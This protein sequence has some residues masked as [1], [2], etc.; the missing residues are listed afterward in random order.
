M[1]FF[2]TSWFSLLLLLV[3]V[4]TSK[5]IALSADFVVVIDIS[6]AANLLAMLMV[7]TPPILFIL[8]SFICISN[9]DK[10]ER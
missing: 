10:I 6:N 4:D 2:N 3:L 7:V 5:I 1:N 8:V 9:F